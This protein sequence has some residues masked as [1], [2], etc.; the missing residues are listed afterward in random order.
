MVNS[1]S[2]EVE[3]LDELEQQLLRLERSVGRK[4]LK[5]ALSTAGTNIV[6]A[7]KKNAPK[8]TGQLEKAIFKS[9]SRVGGVRYIR[10]PE[11]A[12]TTIGIKRYGARGAPHAY[13]QEFGTRERFRRRRRNEID[14]TTETYRISTGRVKGSFFMRRAWR[15]EG[16]VHAINRFK[17]SL[18]RRIRNATR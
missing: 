17:K 11:A 16:G 14:R 5:S 15:Q 4:I 8:R 13:L 12:Q 18:Q 3:G 6:K 1:A 7:A 2:F 10:G 9:T